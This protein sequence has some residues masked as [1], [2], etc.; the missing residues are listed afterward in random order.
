MQKEFMHLSGGQKQMVVIMRS[1][2]HDPLIIYLDEPTKGLDPFASKR[3]RTFL[4]EYTE[5]E[6]K[7]LLLTSHILSEVDE[8]VSRVSLISEGTNPITGTPGELKMGV[9]AKDFIEIRKD[10]MPQSTVEKISK[11]KTVI[12]KLEREADWLSFGVSNFFDGTEDIIRV[13][14][15]DG[16][17][18]GFRHHSVTLEDAFV[19]HL[20]VLNEKFDV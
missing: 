1:L 8:L 14:R 5:K 15:E 4:K 19:H 3:I 9:G 7:S 13:L 2:L 20:G 17:E 11:L 18:A 12:K 16:I 6:G 10:A